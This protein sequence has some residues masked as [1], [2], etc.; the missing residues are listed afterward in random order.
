MSYK[1]KYLKYKLKYLNLKR[2]LLGGVNPSTPPMPVNT[3]LMSRTIVSKET[4]LQVVSN[5]IEQEFSNLA[6][7]FDLIKDRLS[8]NFEELKCLL[9]ICENPNLTQEDKEEEIRE[10]FQRYF[11]ESDDESTEEYDDSDDNPF[12]GLDDIDENV[13]NNQE[14][15]LEHYDI[16]IEGDNILQDLNM[17]LEDSYEEN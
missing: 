11:D 10:K 2:K 13:A 9:I 14:P 17:E 3:S 8:E 7:T 15:E 12:V 1:N 5:K 6:T 16:D 4:I